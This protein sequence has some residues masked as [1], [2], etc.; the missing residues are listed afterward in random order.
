M[1]EVR[2][3]MIPF[4]PS[5]FTALEKGAEKL[6]SPLHDQMTR[7]QHL[8]PK[9]SRTEATPVEI[10]YEC[11]QSIPEKWDIVTRP[12]LAKLYNAGVIE[13]TVMN[14]PSGQAFVAQKEGYR[15][16]LFFDYR[17]HIQEMRLP[18]DL[19]EPPSKDSLYTA[20]R[21]YARDNPDAC[22]ALLRLWA[23]PYFYPL[24]LAGIKRANRSFCDCK[25]RAWE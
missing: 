1:E 22:F 6:K 21:T 2:A 12:V 25:G 4:F 5:S 16:E 7:A 3:A 9:A 8:P 10:L 11:F 17:P 19:H 13:S 24:M 18:S 23:I 14:N 20:A 15:P